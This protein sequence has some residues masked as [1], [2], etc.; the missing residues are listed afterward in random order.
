VKATALATMA[1]ATL[2]GGVVLWALQSLVVASGHP[3]FVPP[4]TW[5]IAL[6]LVGVG[7]VAVAWP[8]H[9]RVASATA[10]GPLDPVYATRVV[11]LAKSSTIAGAAFAGGA[12]G[13]TANL[14]SRPTVTME[15]WGLTG[16][17]GLG[18]IVLWAGGV[19]AE[20]WCTVPPKPDGHES[21]TTGKENL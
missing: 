16:A 5:A 19:I 18:A 2:I 9:R 13:L 10:R 12:A 17:A 3:A 7:I 14:L 6:A 4:V 15:V 11:L 1:A 8:I 21:A 20:R